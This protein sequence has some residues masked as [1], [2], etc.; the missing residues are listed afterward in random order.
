MN[1]KEILKIYKDFNV[2]KHVIRHMKKVK[3]ICEILADCFIKKGIKID[4]KNLKYAALLHDV[5]RICDF[6]DFDPDKFDQ[7]V[8]KYDIKKWKYLRSKYGKIGHVKAMEQILNKIGEKKLAIL[9]KKHDFFE[10]DNLHTWEE[11]I[12]F[13]ADKR[14]DGDKIVILEKRF[15]EGRKR[16]AKNKEEILKAKEI[17]EKVKKLEREL[18]NC[19]EGCRSDSACSIL[20]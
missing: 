1:Q 13:Y 3:E 9:V 15:K 11:K 16:N 18:I 2:P 10:I 4:K 12:I 6:R 7:K 14:A 19:L 8:T 17:E 20:F 5:L